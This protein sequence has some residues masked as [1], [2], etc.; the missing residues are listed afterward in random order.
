MNEIDLE[1]ID[2]WRKKKNGGEK[3]I[4]AVDSMSAIL[5]SPPRRPFWSTNK[6]KANGERMREWKNKRMRKWPN[7]TPSTIDFFRN[8]P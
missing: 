5:F 8:L 7:P 1:W 3:V 6:K 4:A 2:Y